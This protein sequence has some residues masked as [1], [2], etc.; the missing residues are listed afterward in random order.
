MVAGDH[1]VR[2]PVGSV[3][4]CLERLDFLRVRFS[5]DAVLVPD[6]DTEVAVVD[7]IVEPESSIRARNRGAEVGD[8]VF[9]ALDAEVLADLSQLFE[10]LL[11]GFSIGYRT[12]WVRSPAAPASRGA[13]SW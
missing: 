12:E 5:L 13:V 4:L 6:D 8:S 10:L 3:D 11:R 9:V 1:P 7:E 2:L